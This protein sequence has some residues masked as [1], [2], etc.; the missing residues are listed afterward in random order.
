MWVLYIFWRSNS[1]P[2]YHWQINFLIW[3]IPFSFCWC[4][5]KPYRSFYLMKFHLFILSYMSLA[6]GKIS[7]KILLHGISEIFLPMFSYRTYMVLLLIFKS[8]I[9]L[10]FIFVFGVSWWLHSRKKNEQ[11]V[12]TVPPPK[13]SYRGPRDIPKDA[14]HH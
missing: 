13:R 12:W 8:C 6:L 7:V 2:T 3:L 9:H 1:C 10:E 4:F 11:K 14:Q 5:F